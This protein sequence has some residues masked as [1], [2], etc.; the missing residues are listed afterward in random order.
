MST[1]ATTKIN[2]NK[3][4]Y[5]IKAGIVLQNRTQTELS[6]KMGIP[7]IYLNAFL[8]R[9]I[10]LLPEDIE[11]LLKVLKLDRKPQLSATTE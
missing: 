3:A 2:R 11:V 7:R 8:N 6:K 9:R 5:A 1:S 10:D 4:A